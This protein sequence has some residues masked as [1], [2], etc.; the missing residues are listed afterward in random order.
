MSKSTATVT[1][2]TEVLEAA[3]KARINRSQT[4]EDA[5]RLKLKL[6]DE[7]GELTQKAEELRGKLGVTEGELQKK[8]QRNQR[9]APVETRYCDYLVRCRQ[10][11][12]TFPTIIQRR[13]WLEVFAKEI[14]ETPME[15]QEVFDAHAEARGI[16]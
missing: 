3:R 8:K 16:L 1:V 5:L 4:L 13:E 15:L 10:Q 2:D 14:G 9:R 12:G 6:P 11:T 7:E